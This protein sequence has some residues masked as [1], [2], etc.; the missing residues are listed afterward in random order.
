MNFMGVM[1]GGTAVAYALVEIL[2]PE[3]LTPPNGD[4]AIGMLAALFITSLLWNVGTWALGIPNSSS[5]ALIGSLV[6]VS[7]ASTLRQSRPLHEGVDW[8]QILKVLEALL[9]SPVLGFALAW[10]LFR[11][12]RLLFKDQHLY[13]PPEGDTPPVWWMRAILIGTCTGVSFSHGS[14]D[15]QKSIGLIMLTVIGLAPFTFAINEDLAPGKVAGILPQFAS[16]TSLIAKDGSSKKAEG[17]NAATDAMVLMKGATRLSAVPHDKRVRLRA[18]TN[19]VIAELK[20]VG[21]NKA[22]NASKTEQATAK[23][24]QKDLTGLVN[25]VPWWVSD[26]IGAANLQ[27]DSAV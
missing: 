26:G 9:V 25:Y 27:I 17:L 6:R 16:A 5:H 13:E 23:A 7:I 10:L 21:E 3:V 4:P 14:N 20:T 8:S 22:G 2:P 12:V 11:L 18:D 15:G 24:L 1:V 19:R